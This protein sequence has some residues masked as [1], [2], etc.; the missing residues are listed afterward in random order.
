MAL[1]NAKDAYLKAMKRRVIVL[2]EV[3]NTIIDK[4]DGHAEDKINSGYFVLT[5]D[6][7]KFCYID[8]VF[9]KIINHYEEKGFYVRTNC[10]ISPTTIVLDWSK[11][12]KWF[13]TKN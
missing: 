7:S 10:Y 2:D 9:T 4:I 8:Y 11:Q 12:K 13:K 6:L 3:F 1:M 5:M